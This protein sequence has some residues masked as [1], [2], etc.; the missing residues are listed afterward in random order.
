MQGLVD[1]GQ[2]FC[3]SQR[4]A[5]GHI[6]DAMVGVGLDG[7]FRQTFGNIGKMYGLQMKV[8]AAEEAKGGR[9]V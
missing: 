7:K 6:D 4:L 3:Q 1:G 8:S 9:L 2:V 5:A